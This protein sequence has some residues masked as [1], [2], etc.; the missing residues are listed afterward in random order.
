[1]LAEGRVE[2]ATR[3]A[4]RRRM[5]RLLVSC[6]MLLTAHT[7]QEREPVPPCRDDGWEGRE[8]C[9]ERH[10]VSGRHRWGG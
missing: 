5:R 4:A 7:S 9:H 1:V 3:A 2:V 10:W 6:S 8:P